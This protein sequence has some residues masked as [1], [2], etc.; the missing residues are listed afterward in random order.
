MVLQVGDG[1]MGD[2]WEA[3]SERKMNERMLNERKMNERE[4]NERKINDRNKVR[5]E[6]RAV[7]PL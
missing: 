1:M 3:T 7:L 2:E 6:S 4:M 5:G